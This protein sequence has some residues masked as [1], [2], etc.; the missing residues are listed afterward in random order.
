MMGK[1]IDINIDL[2]NYYLSNDELI[3]KSRDL[4][5]SISSILNKLSSLDSDISQT[6]NVKK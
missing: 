1:V 3:R 5:K 4:R 2:E 6:C